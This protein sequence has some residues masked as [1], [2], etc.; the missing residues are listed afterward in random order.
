MS[1]SRKFHYNPVNNS[2]MGTTNRHQQNSLQS[3]STTSRSYNRTNNF[4]TQPSQ[5]ILNK[6]KVN[7]NSEFIIEEEDAKN[8][9][10][11]NLNNMNKMKKKQ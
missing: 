1:T 2:Q 8:T 4:L 3:L 6:Q 7:S 5:N 11:F 9:E 10:D